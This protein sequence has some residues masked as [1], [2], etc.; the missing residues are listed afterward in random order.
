MQY[1]KYKNQAG[2]NLTPPP[3]DY[4]CY[5]CLNTEKTHS[6]NVLAKE[7]DDQYRSM[8]PCGLGGSVE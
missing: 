2:M 5:Y 4:Y 6:K 1:K 3:Y 7:T 8:A